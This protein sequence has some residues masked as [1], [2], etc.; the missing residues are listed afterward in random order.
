[1]ELKEILNIAKRKPQKSE[2]TFGVFYSEKFPS[3]IYRKRHPGLD[4]KEYEYIEENWINP[5]KKLVGDAIFETQKI[6]SDGNY[7]IHSDNE[8]VKEFIETYEIMSFFKNIYW[9]N[10]ILDSDSILTYH[11]KYSEFIDKQRGIEL[12][13]EYLPLHPYLV[14]SENIIYKDKTTLV[15]RVKGD[16]RNNFVA[17][18]YNSDNILTYEHYSYDNLNDEKI[19]PIL[20]WEFNNNSNKRYFRQADGIK[21][22]DGNELVIRSYFSPSESIL[23]TIIIDSVNMGVTKT[24][25]TYPIP[26]VVGEPCDAQE[27]SGGK[28]PS[29]DLDGNYCQ[30]DCTTCKGSGSK[31]VF[32][33]FNA[34]HIVR[35][36]NAMG[37]NTPPAPHVYWVDPPQGALESTRQEIR[38]NRDIAFDY[39]GLRYS[40]SEARGSETAL[41]KMIDREKTFSTYKMYS[42][43]VEMTMQWWFNNW[44]EL[45]FPLEQNAEISVITY[46]NFRTTSTAEVNEIFTAL[47]KDNAPQY[48]LINL[49]KEYYN[50]IGEIDKFNIVNKYYLY[51]SD[52]M[53]IKKGSLGYYDKVQIVISD[54]IMKWVD[55]VVNM[56]ESE[57]DIYLKAKAESL[58]AMP[59]PI[60]GN[61]IETKVVYKEEDESEED[62]LEDELENETIDEESLYQQLKKQTQDA[63]MEVEEIDGKVVVT[64]RPS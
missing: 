4:E 15:Y 42:Q 37:G 9:Q 10:I 8:T 6:F 62:K 16:K 29:C 32:S 38:E 47:Q 25:T 11:I 46:N 44:L 57:M 33:P 18:Y 12:G 30:V 17:L 3:E 60:N 58:M 34:V 27:C 49:L 31:N 64:G 53:N 1:M 14:T 5:V 41:G 54:N 28:I 40:N 45:M 55:E 7:S 61:I 35:D 48:I 24:R 21:I 20:Y 51:K 59:L 2:R 36:S 56:N 22:V 52:D 50:S 19:T 26:V 43:D 13:N 39:I 23:S 63:G